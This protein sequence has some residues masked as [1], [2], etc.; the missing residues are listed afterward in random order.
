MTSFEE[1]AKSVTN[2]MLLDIIEDEK[3]KKEEKEF[4]KKELSLEKIHF[5][6]TCLVF[7]SIA[8]TILLFVVSTSPKCGNLQRSILERCLFIE[9]TFSTD[10]KKF[11]FKNKIACSVQIIVDDV[12]DENVESGFWR[13]EFE[14]T[15][16]SNSSS[17]KVSVN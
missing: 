14:S 7:F 6:G 17:Y 11:K 9:E 15:N 3:N 1:F 16:S 4:C 2:F 10:Q 12:D 8:K 5:S 13:E